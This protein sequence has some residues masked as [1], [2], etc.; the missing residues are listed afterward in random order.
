MR[1]LRPAVALIALLGAAFA[2]DNPLQA[3]FTRM[4]QA[5][6]TFKGLVADMVKISHFA[7]IN[8]DDKQTGTIAVQKKKAHDFKMLTLFQPPDGEQVLIT[9]ARVDIYHPKTNTVQGDDLGKKYRSLAEEFLLLGFG[10]TADELQSGYTV[11][12]GGEETLP[13]GTKATRLVLIPKSKE[14]LDQFPKIELW[15]SDQTGIAVQQKLF[16]KG[17]DYLLATYSNMKIRNVSDAEV[18]LN[19]PHDVHKEH[20]FH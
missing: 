2:A 8:E 20:L 3:V 9:S 6:G 18:K 19:L 5:A 17:G 14:V 10:N 16:E 7:A 13:D 11:T 4:N 12:F 15:I 1:Y